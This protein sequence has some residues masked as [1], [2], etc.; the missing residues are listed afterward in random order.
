MSAT[1]KKEDRAPRALDVVALLAN[2]PE[3]RLARGNVGTIVEEFDDE[4]VLVEFSDDD[5]RPYAVAPCLR[6]ELLLLHYVP[7]AA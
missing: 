5:G 3:H 2:L 6:S 7:E 1:N 4:T